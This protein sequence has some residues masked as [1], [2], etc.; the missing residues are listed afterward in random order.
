MRQVIL[1]G[2]GIHRTA[3][4]CEHCRHIIKE[5]SPFLVSLAEHGTFEILQ[6]HALAVQPAN[7]ADPAA[8]GKKEGNHGLVP[9]AVASLFQYL[10]VDLRIGNLDLLPAL[11]G[12]EIRARITW[13]QSLFVQ[14]AKEAGEHAAITFQCFFANSP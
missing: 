4:P 10:Y 3:F 7:L 8:G 1:E 9:A 12:A 11:D 2:S 14:P 13:Q 5:D 6:I